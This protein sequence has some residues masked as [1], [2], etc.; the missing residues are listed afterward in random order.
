VRIQ[1]NRACGR[2][3]AVIA[4]LLVALLASCASPGVLQPQRNYGNLEGKEL[5]PF[6]AAVFKKAGYSTSPCHHT[7]VCLETSWREYDGDLRGGVRWRERRMYTV[8]FEPEALQ[9]QY[10][11]F[12]ELLVQEAPSAAAEWVGK[13]VA[14]EQDAEYVQLLQEIDR[15]VKQLGGIRY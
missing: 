6:V 13:Q 10:L 15:V 7:R 12:L 9:D 11:L 14:P 5:R 3:R 4:S 1:S 8:W 2:Y